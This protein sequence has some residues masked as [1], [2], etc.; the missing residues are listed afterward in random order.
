MSANF[1][2][3]GYYYD[4]LYFVKS[5]ALQQSGNKNTHP[6]WSFTPDS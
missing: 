6:N 2:A 1:I 3:I 4:L 5:T